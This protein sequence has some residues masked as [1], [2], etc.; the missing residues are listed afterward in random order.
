MLKNDF[1]KKTGR[2]VL[3]CFSIKD[4]NDMM[5]LRSSPENNPFA[6]DDIWRSEKDANEFFDFATLF[7][8]NNPNR[9]S[10]FRYFF[11]IREN[12]NEKVIGFCGL[13]APDFDRNVTEVF[14]GLI[15][16]KWNQ[17]YATEAAQAM[18]DFGFNEIGL[19][20]IIGFTHPNNI[21]S[22]RV[23]EKTGLKEIGVLDNISKAHD[24][25]GNTMFEILS[26]DYVK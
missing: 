23:L 13:G 17:G 8:D 3:R 1:E 12:D 19:N 20:R 2:L 4:F 24:F 10:W 18:L 9:P 5:E 22:R 26:K 21:A 15:H 14:Y 11:A 25:F 6:P 16:T 7:Y